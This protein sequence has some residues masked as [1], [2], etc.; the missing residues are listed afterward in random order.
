MPDTTA[1]IDL[2]SVI[3]EKV[4]ALEGQMN[5]AGLLPTTEAFH[6]AKQLLFK[7][8]T[9]A[10][11][12]LRELQSFWELLALMKL[13]PDALLP[14][15]E[16]RG[17]AELPS[18]AEPM[19]VVEA[20]SM[21][22]ED[23]PDSPPAAE[24]QKLPPPET[25]ISDVRLGGRFDKLIAKIYRSAK[26]TSAQVVPIERLADILSLS[27]EVL[28]KLER[29]GSKYREDWRALQKLY[30]APTSEFSPMQQLEP[31]YRVHDDMIIN[32]MVLDPAE[33][34]ALSKLNRTLGTW[35]IQT[36]LDFDASGG[37]AMVSLGKTS[38]SR[39]LK[40]QQ[41]LIKDLVHIESGALDYRKNE[42]SLIALKMQSFD[43]VAELGIH[44]LARVD[45]YLA[46]LDETRQ[47]IFQHRWGFVD[48]YLTLLEIGEKFELSRERIRQLESAVNE[49][50]RAVLMLDTDEVWQPA[51]AMTYVDLRLHM[52]DLCSCFTNTSHFH[53]FLAYISHGRLGV[54]S[55]LTEPSPGVLDRY[56]AVHG[57]TTS[58]EHVLQHLQQCLNLEEKHAYDAL[59]YL[60]AQDQVMLSDGQVRPLC[61]KKHDAAAAVLSEHASGLPW[62]DIA[63]LA[64][65]KGISKY[66]FSEQ[67]KGSWL[68]D[69]DLMYVSGTGVYRHTRYI[70]FAEIDDELIF[71]TLRNYF[72]GAC[73]E[74]VHLSQVCGE[75]V[76]LSKY[77]YYIVRYIVKM[78]GS[79]HGFFF[80]GKSQ[81]DSVSVNPEFKLYSQKDVIFQAMQSRR[82]PMTKTEIAQLL[83]SRSLEHA[84]FYLLEMLGANLV[85][86]IDRM[87]YT[88]PDLAYEKIDLN[89]MRQAIE[90]IL[91]RHEK[92]V[93]PSVIQHELN[94][95]HGATYSKYFYGSLA[96]YFAQQNYWQRRQNLYSIQ[97]IPFKSLT[98][99]IEFLCSQEASME[100]SIEILRSHIAI[101]DEAAR[102]SIYNWKGAKVRLQ[103][104]PTHI[105][106]DDETKSG[107]IET[108][109][110]GAS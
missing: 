94:L 62:K 86:Q 30:T 61:L 79:P 29:V 31:C 73:R 48:E 97:S 95:K 7:L 40:I 34:S 36:I 98:G 60:Q 82:E 88:S 57:T 2:V 56:F 90:A 76:A 64:N 92:P 55:S 19:V 110:R 72:A 69:S 93:D 63:R 11:L 37:S 66:A 23:F 54:P 16:W 3:A 68:Q 70:N 96:R 102:T 106:A 65:K 35:D 58:Q 24:V 28:M 89:A 51:Q 1:E 13:P 108:S 38:I 39:V 84:S 21:D 75:S 8:D 44:V 5:A 46:E 20:Q 101:T 12:K 10:F 25:P 26:K 18:V 50:L 42:K 100:A 14:V 53:E 83:K 33:R 91:Q 22:G 104:D 99:A 105:N 15:A 32:I 71:D 107:G 77:D 52:E 85:V 103:A 45:I 49:D 41:R 9:E 67:G 87:L 6:N 27:E 81:T 59:F 4:K 80:N 78:R 17:A 47:L 109:G 74:V 43:S